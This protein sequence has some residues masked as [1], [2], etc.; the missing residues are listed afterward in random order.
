[1]RLEY[2]TIPTHVGGSTIGLIELNECV[3]LFHILG[4]VSFVGMGTF[5]PL[6]PIL[7]RPYPKPFDPL[8]GIW[9]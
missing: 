1:L 9:R 8:E 2:L 7:S 4:V 5:P 3:E 6:S